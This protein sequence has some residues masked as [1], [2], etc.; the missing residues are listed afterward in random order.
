MLRHDDLTL[1]LLERI[2]LI[3]R[4]GSVVDWYRLGFDNRE[5]VRQFLRVNGYYPEAAADERRCRQLFRASRD[6][7]ADELGIILPDVVWKPVNIEDPFLLASDM[8]HPFQRDACILLKVV[9]TINHLEARELRFALS[10]PEVD[11]FSRVETHVASRMAAIC[12][13]GYPIVSFESSRK[14]ESST[15]TKLL[16]KRRATAAQILDRLRFRIVVDRQEDL[17]I[18]LAEMTRRLIPFNYVV[19]EET[20]NDVLDFASYAASLTKLRGE[21]GRLQHELRLES[22]EPLRREHN[23]CS[24]DTFRMLNF[25]ID[26]PLRVNDVLERSEHGHLRE[27]GHLIFLNVEFQMFDDATWRANEDN[28]IASHESYKERQRERVRRRLFHGIE[29]LRKDRD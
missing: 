9:H 18:V 12:S 8:S 11:V 19:P 10:L 27:L 14:T 4:G 2:R 29:P 5:E 22:T 15:I 26:W 17:P 6:Y 24:A 25:V 1:G 13:A 21:L 16:S 3:L 23:E 28:V 20:T 7:L